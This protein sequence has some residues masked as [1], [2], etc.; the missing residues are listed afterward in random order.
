MNVATISPISPTPH[1]PPSP[2]RILPLNLNLPEGLEIFPIEDPSAGVLLSPAPSPPLEGVMAAT[3]GGTHDNDMDE[4]GQQSEA[5]G[6]VPPQPSLKSSL[7]QKISFL[8]QLIEEHQDN[9]Q[10]AF[11][12]MS[13]GCIFS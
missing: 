9:L 2:K 6:P 11:G 7:H 13:V 4:D 5:A 3:A 10:H 12:L 8:V 1:Q